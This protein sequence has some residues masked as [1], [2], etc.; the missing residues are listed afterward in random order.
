M[1]S[2][3]LLE[4][5][6]Q[7]AVAE[8]EATLSEAGRQAAQ[9]REEARERCET[10]RSTVTTEVEAELESLASR[11]QERAEAAAEMVVKTTRDTIADEVLGTVEDALKEI[12]QSAEFPAILDALLAEALSGVD[13]STEVVVLAPPSHVEHCKA[14]LAA[15][16][17]EQ[18]AVEPHAALTDG[19][20]VQDPNRSFRV[21]N[22]LTARFNR[23]ES[24]LRKMCLNQLFDG[25]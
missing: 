24:A 14:W 25:E 19:V 16:G 10:R 13:G 20:A 5:M 12:A 9:I 2:P 11:G 7:Q 15:N 17:H 23:R 6:T 8:R 1:Q 18:L 22:T 3:P 4:L 21:T